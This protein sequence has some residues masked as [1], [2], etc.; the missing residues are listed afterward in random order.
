MT[1]T[2]AAPGSASRRSLARSTAVV[3]AALMAGNLAGYLLAVIGSHR[4]RPADYGL[5]GSMLAILLVGSIPALALQAVVARRTAAE[6]LPLRRALRDGMMT[7]L[8]SV[9][10]GLAAWPGL[11]P[12]LHVGHHG[13][14]LLFAVASLLPLNL[15]GAVQGHLQ[16]TERFGRLAVVVV[17]IGVG[18]LLGGVIPLVLGSHATGVMAG[19]AIATL[20]SAG[21]ALRVVARAV[22]EPAPQVSPTTRQASAR[23]ELVTATLSM[24][25]L[26]LLSSLDLLL[27]RHLLAA[28]T[29]GRY[30]AGNVVAKAAFWLPQAVPLTA[31][32]RLSRSDDRAKAL[33]D[34]AVLTA[35]IAA[36]SIAVTAVA[37]VF[38]VRL[39]FGAGYG[40]IGGVAWL[41]ALQGSALAGVQ[42]LVFHD[43][44]ARRR[45]VVPIVLIAAALETTIVLVAQPHSPRAIIAI[46]AAIAV[47]LVA[48]TALRHQRSANGD[49]DRPVAPSSPGVDGSD[50]QW[51]ASSQLRPTPIETSSDT[52]RV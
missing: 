50:D 31:L 13:V 27:A 34:A 2:V 24:G 11:T 22:A 45:G 46:A 38:L 28:S 23:P 48:I 30:A 37:G 5:F 14:A 33:R 41:F 18:R 10:V 3:G 19:V 12:F 25:A 15:L 1:A 16:G 49:A 7:G 44:A 42:L 35:A 40:S 43:I 9:A 21:I 51:A 47:A 6:H 39:T 17:V 8:A 36:V 32:P 4:L 26:L 20:L 29:A 52:S